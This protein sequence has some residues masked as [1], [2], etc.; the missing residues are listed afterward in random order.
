MNWLRLLVALITLRSWAL[1]KLRSCCSLPS[2]EYTYCKLLLIKLSA[3]WDVI[4]FSTN[5]PMW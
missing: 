5:L 1:K 4:C 2:F 3:K